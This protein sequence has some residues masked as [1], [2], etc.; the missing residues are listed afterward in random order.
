MN[1]RLRPSFLATLTVCVILLTV[2]PWVRGEF[3]RDVTGRDWV[4]WPQHQRVDVASGY[5]M[6]MMFAAN[7]L[8]GLPKYDQPFFVGQFHDRTM[9]EIVREVDQWY[10]DTGSLDTPVFVALFARGFKPLER[11]PFGQVPP[12]TPVPESDVPEFELEETEGL[13][14]FR[15]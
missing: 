3:L 15:A 5:V 7:F 14:T 9:E 13:Q 8:P 1:I 2:T 4:G 6:A 11:K 12:E 10:R